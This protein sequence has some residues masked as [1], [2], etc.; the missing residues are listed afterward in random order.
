MKQTI[1]FVV[2]LLCCTLSFSQIYY[3]ADFGP[4]LSKGYD[5][6]NKETKYGITDIF[7]GVPVG[8]NIKLQHAGI[9]I[10]MEPA[11]DLSF[12]T[13]FTAQA[14]TKIDFSEHSGIHLLAG[15]GYDNLEELAIKNSFFPCAKF[16]L[17]INRVNLQTTYINSRS[18]IGIG[19]IG[20][21]TH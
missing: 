13:I 11:M 21:G 7:F 9:L 12:T 3:G 8:Y 18:Y 14:G 2:A 1:L 17:W 15:Y 5:G 10:E 20:F 6:V 19:V 16:R 4:M